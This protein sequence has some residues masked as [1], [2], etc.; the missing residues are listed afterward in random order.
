MNYRI[1]I[2]DD[3][4]LARM[5]AAKVLHALYPAWTRVE[6]A[7]AEEAAAALQQAAPDIALI[8]FNMPGKSGLDFAEDIRRLHPDMPV[9]VISANRQQDVLERARSIGA[10]FL[11]KPVS[12]AG[13]ADFLSQAVIRLAKG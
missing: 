11:T 12:E 1:L 4:K 7:N 3:S 2:V 5:A 8:D 13:L 9:A 6:A 10:T